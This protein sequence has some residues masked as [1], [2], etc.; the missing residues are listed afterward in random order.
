[1]FGE[2]DLH[3]LP[4]SVYKT[5]LL[6]TAEAGSKILSLVDAVDWQVENKNKMNIP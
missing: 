2:L 3:G 5:K 1:V 4:H 6:E